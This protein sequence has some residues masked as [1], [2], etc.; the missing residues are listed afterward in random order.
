MNSSSVLRRVEKIER[1]QV[2]GRT[3]VTKTETVYATPQP[4]QIAT[5]YLEGTIPAVKI[6]KRSR[7]W[8]M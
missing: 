4:G 2:D 8:E 7:Y 6:V 3:L 5:T 1:L